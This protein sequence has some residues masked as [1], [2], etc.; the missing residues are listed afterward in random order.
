MMEEHQDL[1]EQI[2][3]IEWD[4]FSRVRSATPAPC[5]SAPD[6]FKTIRGSNYEMWSKEMLESYLDDLKIAQKKGRNL[7]TSKY[8]RMDNLI[9][10]LNT[11]PLINKIVEIET[12]WQKEILEKFPVTYDRLCRGTSQAQDGSNFSVYLRCEIETYS[13]KTIELYYQHV[14]IACDNEENNAISALQR[15]VKKGGFNDLD[16]AEA[17][18][19]RESLSRKQPLY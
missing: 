6:S 1:I 11:N 3:A 5:Q 13:N 2:L 18:L 19:K 8:A 12:E 17:F 9:P 7:V 10:S 15:L 14:K 4:M 16:H